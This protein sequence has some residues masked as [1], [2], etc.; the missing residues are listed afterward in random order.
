MPRYGSTDQVRSFASRQYVEPARQRGEKT[1]H[2]HSGEINRTL[3]DTKVLLPNRFPI[4]CNA[5]KSKKFLEDNRLVL[6]KVQGPASGLSSTVTFIYRLDDVSS[7]PPI[8][9]APPTVSRFEAMRGV[10]RET[11]KQLGGA[12][13]FHRK[14]RAAWN[15]ER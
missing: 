1:V 10:L 11:Y 14:E 15:E 3:V 7:M 12:E 9:P 4:I 8:P 6:E 2:I 13:A 5:L